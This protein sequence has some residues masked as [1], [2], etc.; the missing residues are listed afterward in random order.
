MRFIIKIFCPLCCFVLLSGAAS[1]QIPEPV[2]K[3]QEYL[4]DNKPEGYSPKLNRL[5]LTPKGNLHYLFPLYHALK[6]ST[7][8]KQIYSD[9]GYFDELS[10]FFAFVGDYQ[11]ALHYLLRSYDTVDDATRRKIYKMA[12]GAKDIEHVDARRYLSFAARSTRVIMINE[13]WSKPLHRAFTISILADLYRQGYRY[14]AME[15]LNNFSNH[16]LTKVNMHT[17]YYC[18]EP[19]AAELART[20]LGLGYTLVSYE[21]TA[22]DRHTPEQRDSVQAANLA[23]IFEADTSAKM[24]VHASYAHISKKKGADGYI[25][26]GLRFQKITGIVPLTV[27]QTDMSEESNFA[28]GRAWYQA[29][30]QKYTLKTASVA[31]INNQAVNVT[32]NDLYDLSVIHPPSM[33]QE[34]R[35]TWLTLGG[36]RRAMYVKPP[37]TNAFMV[38][39]YYQDE[40]LGNGGKPWQLIPAD[41]SYYQGVKKIFLL[42]LKKGKYQLVFRDIDYK[43][44]KTLDIE[45]N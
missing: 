33:Y 30:M 10:Q 34:G 16:D 19:V 6:D 17:G 39:A 22:A 20:A 36:L 12:E 27:D 15:M 11:T 5:I 14:L 38:Q 4:R 40:I 7:K 26:M 9:K 25:P 3:L 45:V 18:A 28:Y 1:A 13:S 21:D 8:F 31:L 42:Y 37:V 44:Q 23:K 29:Y 24:L 32:N 41:Q 2:Q 43:I 35:P